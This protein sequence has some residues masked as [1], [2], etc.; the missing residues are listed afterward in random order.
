MAYVRTG[1][2]YQSDLLLILLQIETCG[3]LVS[4]CLCGS[5]LSSSTHFLNKFKPSFFGHC[6]F[7]WFDVIVSSKTNSSPDKPKLGKLGKPGHRMSVTFSV[8]VI[9]LYNLKALTVLGAHKILRGE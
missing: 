4:G 7:V 8:S 3:S 1:N 6:R 2:T 9:R 5:A